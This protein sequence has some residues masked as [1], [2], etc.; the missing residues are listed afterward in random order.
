MNLSKFIS[1]LEELE[2][3]YLKLESDTR[4]P[5]IFEHKIV[6]EFYGKECQKLFTEYHNSAKA[7]CEMLKITQSILDFMHNYTLMDQQVTG[8]YETFLNRLAEG[9]MGEGKG[10]E[11]K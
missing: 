5:A 3:R 9:A 10:E 6:A 2:A 4:K 7:V 8:S 11:K 1:K